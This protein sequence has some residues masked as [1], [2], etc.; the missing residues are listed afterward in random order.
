MA[1]EYIVTRKTIIHFGAV[2]KANSAAEAKRYAEEYVYETGSERGTS[3]TKWKAQPVMVEFSEAEMHIRR[4]MGYSADGRERLPDDF[5]FLE[6][7]DAT[8]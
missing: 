4:Q 1:Q 2:V 3:D 7:H 6:R 8:V 5:E